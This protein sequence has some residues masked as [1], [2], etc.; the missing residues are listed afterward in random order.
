MNSLEAI[1]AVVMMLAII[2]IVVQVHVHSSKMLGN[3]EWTEN[4][5]VEKKGNILEETFVLGEGRTSEHG[6]TSSYLRWYFV[7]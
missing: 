3:P 5:Q 6:K 4:I 1:I 2:G 7:S